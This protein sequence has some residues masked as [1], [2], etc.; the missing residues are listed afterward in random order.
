MS[1]AKL[2]MLNVRAKNILPRYI[3]KCIEY[4]LLLIKMFIAR[5][6][7][8]NVFVANYDKRLPS[9]LQLYPINCK[10]PYGK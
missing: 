4:V 7:V 9:L 8:F 2:Q 1:F 5:K 10:Y 3:N 6:Y